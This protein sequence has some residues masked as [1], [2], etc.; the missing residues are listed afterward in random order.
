VHPEGGIGV[1]GA[2]VILYKGGNERRLSFALRNDGCIQHVESGLFLHPRGGFAKFGVDLILHPDGPEERLAFEL[3]PKFGCLRHIR[4]GLYIH[5]AGGEGKHGV[6]L[7]LHNDGPEQRLVYE[8]MPLAITMEPIDIDLSSI[9]TSPSSM[10][11]HKIFPPLF[12]TRNHQASFH[13]VLNH[14]V[15]NNLP[16]YRLLPLHLF[17]AF[18]FRF[19]SALISLTRSLTLFFVVDVF[20]TALEHCRCVCICNSSPADIPKKDTKTSVR[21][22]SDPY[23]CACCDIGF[24]PGQVTCEVIMR[25]LAR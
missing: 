18:K 7:L 12:K 1:S 10:P 2:R 19:L 16:Y 9:G 24:C 8:F 3:E 15:R 21:M 20:V 14:E 4:S 23:F 25:Q 17:F 5:P 13:Y 22:G 11:Y 6:H